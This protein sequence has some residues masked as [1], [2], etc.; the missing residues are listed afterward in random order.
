MYLSTSV[1]LPPPPERLLQ[2]P[3]TYLKGVGPFKASLLQKELQIFTYN[4]LL[5]YFPFRYLDRTR[6]DQIVSLHAER[7]FVQ[8]VVVLTAKKIRGDGGKK[9]LIVY[10]QD[11]TGTIELVWFKGI[12]WVEKSIQLGGTY[13]VYGRLTSFLGQYQ[14]THPD[15]EAVADKAQQ[16]VPHILLEPVYPSTEKLRNVGLTGRA[17]GKLTAQLIEQ[18]SG[19]E[20][21]EFLPNTLLEKQKFLTRDQS[22]KNIHFPKS[23]ELLDQALRRVKFEEFFV[24][25]IQLQRIKMLRHQD[26]AGGAVFKVVGD[27][28]MDFYKHHLPFPLTQAQKRVLKEIKADTEQGYQMNRLLQGDVGSGKTIVAFLSILIALGNGYQACLMAPTEILARQHF[29]T[30]SNYAQGLPI[31]IALLVGALKK[32][33]RKKILL[34]LSQHEIDIVIGTHAL[35][36]DEVIFKKL[37]FVVIDEQHRFGVEQ[38]AKLW[39][40][41]KPAPHVLVMTATPIPRTLAMTVYGDLDQSILDQLPPGRK[42]IKTVVRYETHRGNVMGFVRSQIDLGRQ[43][44]IVYPLIEESE[45][46]RY[47]DLEQ[48]IVQVQSYLPSDRYNLSKLH[49]RMSDAEKDINMKRFING[50]SQVMVATTV[51]EVG[52]NVPNATVMV[53]ESAEKF[54]LSQ[55]HQLR[56]RVGRGAEL[57]YCIL[58]TSFR[59]SKEAKARLEVIRSTTDGFQI[60][61]KDLDMR[62]PGEFEG[63]KQS[64]A[65]P[66]KVASLVLD[67]DINQLAQQAVADLMVA[68]PVL[69]Q[70]ENQPLKNYLVKLSPN[71]TIQLGKIS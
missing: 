59:L 43:A 70:P 11:A 15:I 37:G 18:L 20:L 23:K 39:Q 46:L 9:R 48:G 66:F 52:V 17:L 67:Q 62:G 29:Q 64:G 24:A 56:G 36:E 21:A 7:D 25:H 30:I 57:S 26:K 53:I 1:T 22:L 31:R 42:P 63:T 65:L 69:A 2:T 6:I 38:R 45:K 14:I 10:A 8:L 40:K 4:D 32:I 12:A 49:G 41:A 55:L 68:D 3:I 13:L 44:Y 58:L 19:Y 33:E 27:V 54:G 50:T 5:L 51:I 71:N 60:A 47:E 61:Q 16:E 28:F 35:I 34:Q